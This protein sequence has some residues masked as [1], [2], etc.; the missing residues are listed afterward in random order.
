VPSH[1]YSFSFAPNP[2]WSRTFSG[3][4]EIQAYLQRVAREHG[5]LPHV[6]FG[7]ELHEARWDDAA[8]R[9]HLRTAAGELTAR[10]LVTG[11]GPLSE[12]S[13]P[14]IPG[15]D[16]FRGTTFH[17]ATWRDD[18]DLTGERV[19]VIGT[20]AS[21]IQFVPHVQRRAAHLTLF[22]RTPPWVLPRRDRRISEVEKKAFRR[23]PALQKLARGGIYTM[24]ESW[25]LGFA[26]SQKV[27]AVAEAQARAFLRSQVADP[28]LRATLTPD[29]RLGCKRVLLSND[30]YPALAQPNVDVV[31]SRVVEVTPTGVVSQAADGTRTE[32]EVDTIIWG[33]GFTVTDQPIAHRVV[34]GDGRTL[35][36]HWEGS[37]M[38]AL[39]GTAIAGFPN[40][41][42]L[43]GPNTGL[44]HTS[45]VHIIESQLRYLVDALATM[46]R[47]GLAA[48]APRQDAQDRDNARIQQQLAGTVWNAGGCASWYLDRHGRN[49]T[50]WPTFTF[51]FRRKLA[52]FDLSEYVAVPALAPAPTRTLQEAT[53]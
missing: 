48:V 32:H 52:S 51:T 45:I 27:M 18:H 24:R 49:T 35:A 9:W 13:I 19:A 50:L 40:L 46:D 8:Q 34:G 6:R 2:D 10:V 15:L 26:G 17:S 44:G 39:H 22:Q 42:M 30:Y 33:T 47:A 43:V 3:Q 36:Q 21:A 53:A 11:T 29:Y 7:A 41:F 4:A 37:G 23:L 14:A 12:P 16:G 28:G 38:Q 20:G 5:V 31:P 25:I 1:L